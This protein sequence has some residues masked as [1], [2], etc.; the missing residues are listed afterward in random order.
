MQKWFGRHRRAGD[1][2]RSASNQSTQVHP[3]FSD[4][5]DK[6]PDARW[7]V[8]CDAEFRIDADGAGGLRGILSHDGAILRF[9]TWGG[10]ERF[11]R[12]PVEFSWAKVGGSAV[13]VVVDGNKVQFNRLAPLSSFVGEPPAFAAPEDED[14]AT[15]LASWMTTWAPADPSPLTSPM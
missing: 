1:E 12:S 6:L 8:A 9:T 11:A 4:A 2:R 15:S 13:H 10:A 3:F 5:L 7:A 14:L